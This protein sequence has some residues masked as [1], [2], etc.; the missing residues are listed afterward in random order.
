MTRWIAVV[1]ALFLMGCSRVPEA[2][3][4]ESP[5]GVPEVGVCTGNISEVFQLSHLLRTHP[6]VSRWAPFSLT[7]ELGHKY[8]QMRLVDCNGNLTD[9]GRAW[10]QHYRV[11][12]P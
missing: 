10:T 7:N 9:V 3:V 2:Q 8:H 11:Y 4:L 5:L 1:A 6:I 12:I